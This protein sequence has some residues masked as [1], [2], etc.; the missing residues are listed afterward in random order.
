MATPPYTPKFQH[1]EWVDN[2]DRVS[3]G[4][5][6]GFNVRFLAIQEDLFKLGEVVG[7]LFRTSWRPDYL[8]S[9]GGSG[10]AR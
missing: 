9:I 1:Q 7:Q 10:R 8:R 3:A 5:L 6:N 2:V 4:G